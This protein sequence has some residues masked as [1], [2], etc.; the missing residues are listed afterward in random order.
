MFSVGFLNWYL[1]ANILVATAA[2]LLTGVCAINRRLARP[3][4]YQHLLLTGYVSAAAA[5]LLPFAGLF[6]EH[7]DPVLRTAQ[8]WYAP[9]MNGGASTSAANDRIEV[10]LAPRS[11]SISL[12]AVE[13]FAGYLFLSG[14]LMLLIRVI[15]DAF[16]IRRIIANA[17]LLRRFGRLCVLASDTSPIPFSF[18]IPGKSFIVVPSELLLRPS[19]LRMAFRHEAQHHR[20]RDTHYLY[21]FQ[22]GRALFY[23]NPAAHWLVRQIQALQ[24]LACD[25]AVVRRRK[26]SAQEYCRCL[27]WV[28]EAAVKE[29]GAL[30]RVCMVSASASALRLRIESILSQPERYLP[31]ATAGVLCAVAVTMLAALSFAVATPIQD[32]RVSPDEARRMAAIARQGSAFPVTVNESVVEQ[33]NR[34]LG[35]PDGRAYLKAAFVRMEQYEAPIFARLEHHGLPPELIAVPLVESGFQ[36]LRALADPRRG[37]GIWM[38]IEATARRFGL[39][40]T[41][42]VDERLDVTAQTEAAMRMLAGLYRQF[43]DWELAL[44]A[45]NIGARRVEQGIRETGSRDAWELIRRGY[46]NDPEYLARL[47]AAVL[48]LCNPAVLD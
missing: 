38:F 18:W 29:E 22:L 35:T 27:L 7:Q 5:F 32:N 33:L 41:N 11:A 26:T 4:S 43:N 40:V 17:Q 39:Q 9:T 48:I 30:V 19:E 16:A 46:E 13:R 37:A 21:L 23:W 20:Q 1:C 28:A 25:E 15:V 8:V 45:Y 2:L 36:N 24:E 12:S 14:V 34:L 6:P 3:F 42:E 10:T 31:R 47:M 44:L